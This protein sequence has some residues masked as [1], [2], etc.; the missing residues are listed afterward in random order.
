MVNKKTGEIASICYWGDDREYPVDIPLDADMEIRIVND[1]ENS[2][3]KHDTHKYDHIAKMF[4]KSASTPL[5]Q[6]SY[7]DPE[8]LAL[9]AE[10]VKIKADIDLKANK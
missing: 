7:V 9:R 10:L 8:I 1:V 3:V 4:I 5:I 2:P 6:A